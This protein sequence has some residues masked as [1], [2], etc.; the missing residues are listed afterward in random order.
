M[1][2]LSIS[3]KTTVFKTFAIS[4]IV[5]L[6]LA[7]VIP[8]SVILELDKIKK[9][10]I[11][12]SVNPKIKQDTLFKDYENG[13]LKNVDVTFKIISLQCSR[14]NDSVKA[15]YMTGN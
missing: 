11:L 8:D 7:K 3:S 13:G 1:W 9:H 6:A 15:A 12:K 14:L 2:N 10:F 4:K 5:H